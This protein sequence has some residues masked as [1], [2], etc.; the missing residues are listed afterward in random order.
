MNNYSVVP[1]LLVLSGK[2]FRVGKKFLWA[3]I[4]FYMAYGGM[5]FLASRAYFFVN[6]IF[7]LALV[8]GSTLLDARSNSDLLYCSLPM[9]RRAI[10]V[11]RYLGA[12]L[13]VVGG[14]IVCY[15]YGFL[16]NLV[17]PKAGSFSGIS[18]TIQGLLPFVS[19][20]LLVIVFYFPF[21]FRYGFPK[22]AFAF[23]SA[24]ITCAAALTLILVISWLVRFRSLNGFSIVEYVNRSPKVAHAL[25]RATSLPIVGLYFLLMGIG[26]AVSILLSIRLYQRRDF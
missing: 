20:T 1:L 4:P 6:G 10:V 15:V 11:G 25:T 13:L 19:W 24:V 12:L 16:L 9:S 22:G 8:I 2:D 5:F 26:I 7:I 18:A 17:Y 14:T 23:I 3:I 21:Y